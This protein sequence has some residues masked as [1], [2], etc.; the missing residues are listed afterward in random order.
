MNLSCSED[1]LVGGEKWST[2]SIPSLSLPLAFFYPFTLFVLDLK[3]S[4]PTWL[5]S[6]KDIRLVFLLVKREQVSPR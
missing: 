2:F 3:A 6:S 5:Q 4:R 1:R